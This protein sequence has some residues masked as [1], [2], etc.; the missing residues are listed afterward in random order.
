MLPELTPKQLIAFLAQ[1][2]EVLHNPDLGP[3]WE[4]TGGKSTAGYPYVVFD[5]GRYLVTRLVLNATS[6][7]RLAANE[8]AC[9]QCDNP[10]CIR[11]AHLFGASRLLNAADAVLKGRIPHGAAHHAARLTDELVLT[12]R[13]QVATGATIAAVA[14]E[15]NISYQTAHRAVLG[16]NWKHLP[17]PTF[18]GK[19]PHV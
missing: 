15:H 2:R 13:A 6:P 7:I 4:W 16:T 11:P 19:T 1:T 12:M 18:G 17:L 3:C 9:H 14:R 10:P 8:D 5:G